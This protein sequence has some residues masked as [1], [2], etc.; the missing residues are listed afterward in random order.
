[1]A[2]IQPYEDLGDECYSY[3]VKGTS[4]CKGLSKLRKKFVSSFTLGS[5]GEEGKRS[6]T[7]V[8]RA[9]HYGASHLPA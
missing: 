2:R 7:A 8:P 6:S 3:S 9:S 5:A 1:M 4:K